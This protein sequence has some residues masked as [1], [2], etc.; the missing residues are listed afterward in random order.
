[1]RRYVDFVM[2]MPVSLAVHQPAGAAWDA[3]MAELRWVDE[4]FSTHRPDSFIS[5]LGRGEIALIDC[6]PE[7]AEVLAIGAAAEHV[8]HGA[9]SIWRPGLDPAGVVKGWAVDRAARHLR[10]SDFCLSAGGDMVCRSHGEPWRV[11]IENP[12]DPQQLIATV[13]VRCGAV[14]TSGTVHRGE[15]LKDAR[16]GGVPRDIAS[17]TVV[18]PSLTWADVDAT[19]GYALGQQCGAW[20]STRP[21]RTGLVVWADATTSLVEGPAQVLSPLTV[22]YR[23]PTMNV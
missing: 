12:L 13:P 8:S 15:H 20:L 4:V 6:P 3:V 19:A 5:R 10:G 2:G 14:A 9:F 22:G 1:M 17:V 23:G 21:G 18:A 16:T 11:G 7:V